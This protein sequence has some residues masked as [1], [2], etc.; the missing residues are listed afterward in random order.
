MIKKFF[1]ISFIDAKNNHEPLRI[2]RK[3]YARW[4]KKG[5]Q[6]M[7][8]KLDQEYFERYGITDSIYNKME[9]YQKWIEKNEQNIHQTSPLS[10]TPLVSV[11]T[12]VYNTNP[13]LLQESIES[14]LSQTYTNW[15]L[16]IAD[17]ASTD[18]ET[19]KTLK[20]YENH[21]R[22]KICYRSTNG[23][24]SEASNSALSLAQGE[25]ITFLDHDDMLAPH[26]LYEMVKKLNENPA[27]K[28]IYSDEDKIDENDKRFNP[29]FK[30]G[31]NPDMFF[32]QNYICHLLLLK[33]EIVDNIGG[34]RKG[35]EGAQDYDLLL[36]SLQY[37]KDNQIDRVEKI[38]YHWRAIKGSTAYGTGEKEYAHAAGIKA[39]RDFF[40]QKD[41]RIT[42]EDGLMPT[43]YKVTYPIY[44]L[45]TK[46]YRLTT[47]D[48]PLVSLLIPTRDRYNILHKC[49]ES[50]RQKTHYPN[51]E[52]I[53]LDNET[54]CPKTLNY[55]EKIKS[56]KNVTILEYH[57]P[58]NYSAINNFGVKHARGEIIGL[59]NNDIEIIN[60]GWLTEMV[61]HALRPEI[62]AVGAKLYYD[63]ATI[64]HA[65]VVL[66]IG[67]V[68]GHSHK[69]F[70]KD[71]YGYFSRL[72]IT[73]NY[74]AVTGACLLVR[75]KL[76]QEVNGLDEKNLT[77][78]FNDVD[79]C[80]KLLEKGYRNLWTP[81]AEAYHHE[82][83][84]RGAEDNP[85]KVKRFNQ[86]VEY[87]KKRWKRLL[88]HDPCY[89]NNLTKRYENFEISTMEN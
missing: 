60:E 54:T 57:K 32:S 77:V 74:S 81:Y 25:Y 27:L 10:Y 83:I 51:Y 70:P 52:I 20:T 48:Y 18:P 23:H 67:G 63:N 47:N 85:E 84:S 4:K 78:A 26:A 29:H 75:K 21:P 2:F 16:C 76:Y 69:Y 41:P 15:E 61:Q 89:N 53:V 19:I 45:S 38:L 22:I 5:L 64:Q 50:I 73:Q 40:A 62:G 87:M 31:W 30:S 58:F 43:T 35:Y 17:D 80:L 11:I 28:L 6:H 33:K 49:I 34:F 8:T 66:G 55:F 72:K 9:Q 88:E 46:D 59:V 37:I 7:L 39:L 56:Y 12:P 44:R 13:K 86:E 71:S 65:G 1:A 24:I 68:A 36:R 79:F 14:V 82:S 3:S 42:V